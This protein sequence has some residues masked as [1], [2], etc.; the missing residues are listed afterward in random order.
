MGVG[1][2]NESIVGSKPS[3]ITLDGGW[4]ADGGIG[5]VKPFFFSCFGVQ[6]VGG[7]VRG[8]AEVDESVIG[9]GEVAGI[10]VAH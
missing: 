10:E 4:K 7:I 5:E 9:S 3:F 2:V 6:T 8:G 1:A